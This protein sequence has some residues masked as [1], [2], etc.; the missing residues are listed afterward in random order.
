MVGFVRTFKHPKS[1][2]THQGLIKLII[3]RVLARRNQ[4]WEKF[5]GQIQINQEPALLLVIP[6]EEV[7]EVHVLVGPVQNQEDPA[8]E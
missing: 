7:V 3:L 8:N 5:T 2:L 6:I 1:S 4:T